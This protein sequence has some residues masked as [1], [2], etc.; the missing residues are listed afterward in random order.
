[1]TEHEDIVDNVISA[2]GFSAD[3]AAWE[4]VKA[5]LRALRIVADAARAALPYWLP[6][7]GDESLALDRALKEAGR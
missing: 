5:E 7:K 6:F 1:M 4:R 2:C 3:Q